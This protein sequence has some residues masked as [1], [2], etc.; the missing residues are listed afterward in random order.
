[1]WIGDVGQG[2]YEE[3][4]YAKPTEKGLNWGWP[5]REGFHQ[6]EGQRGGAQPPGGRNP[7]IERSHDNGDCAIIG[8]YVYRGVAIKGFQGTYVHG[9]GCTG[10][11]RALVQKGG[12]AVQRKALKLT[13]DGLASF[14]ENLKGEMY[15]VS[16]F[17]TIYRLAPK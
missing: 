1:M 7:I 2:L 5:L 12:R 9:D 6:Y 11:L 13:V 8:G 14:G 10:Q 16:R 4:D 15:V 17:G 3:I